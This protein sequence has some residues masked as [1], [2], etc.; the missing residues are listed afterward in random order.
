MRVPVAW[1][2]WIAAAVPRQQEKVSESLLEAASAS[3]V[4]HTEL[5]HDDEQLSTREARIAQLTQRVRDYT[6]EGPPPPRELATLIVCLVADASRWAFGAGTYERFLIAR[7]EPDTP[8]AHDDPALQWVQ[9]EDGL[10]A[11]WMG[12]ACTQTLLAAAEAANAT[13]TWLSAD[14]TSS[15]S[16]AL[17][18][19]RSSSIV[20]RRSAM[21]LI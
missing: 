13:S 6:I 15:I 14:V 4:S 19:R 2:E 21:P 9:A 11:S 10:L 3:F 20:G 1:S 5:T 16:P 8:F 18:S 7:E 12:L 17:L